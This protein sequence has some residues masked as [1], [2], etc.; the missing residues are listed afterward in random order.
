MSD[1]KQDE[2]FDEIKDEK[3]E[4]ITQENLPVAKKKKG[5]G[6]FYAVVG[7]L[8]VLSFFMGMTVRWYSIDP[9]MRTLIR[10]K[11]AMDRQYYNEISDDAFYGALFGA[12]NEEVL[13][14]YSEYMT[15]EQYQKMLEESAGRRDGIGLSFVSADEKLTKIQI[16]RVALGSPAEKAG[17]KAGGYISGFGL[18]ESEV[19]ESTNYISF[20]NFIKARNENEPFFVR[21]EKDGNAQIVR[22]ST[23]VYVE[24]FVHYRTNATAGVFQGTKGE[25]AQAGE[26]LSCLDDQTAY[27]RLL[28]FT[29]NS[30][31]EFSSAMKKFKADN[32]KNLV[33]D[34]RGNGGGYMDILSEIAKYFCKDTTSA[35]PL[36]A[37]ADYGEK[38]ERFYA[39]GNVYSQ[40]FA[41]D[42]QIYVLADGNTASA[43]E[44]LIGCMLDYGTI[45][46]E[47]ICLTEFNGVAK[48]YGKGIMQ[49]TY[50]IDVIKKDALRLTT[51]RVLWPKTETCIHDRG[52]TYEDGTKK[53][54]K[55][56][57]G[58]SEVISAIEK[59]FS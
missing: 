50:Y 6:G 55:N 29:G 28:K 58:D 56:F 25:W 35:K 32:K 1:E 7:L 20:Y 16:E 41:Q 3:K 53:T 5:K 40:Y 46:Y 19:S 39:N 47:D 23:Q 15:P 26:T 33:L 31:V 8:L 57:N 45:S 49:T 10:I 27:I 59:L 34:L 48:T 18:T 14:P 24:N 38:R 37:I 51:A 9:Q 2:F 52:V 30:A 22:L 43:S 12:I 21:Y 44:C 4:E 13:D 36:I 17:L 42:S 54:G 11:Q